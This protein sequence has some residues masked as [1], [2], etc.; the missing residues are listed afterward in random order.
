MHENV[1]L[2]EFGDH[3]ASIDE[4]NEVVFKQVREDVR[5][6]VLDNVLDDQGGCS[7]LVGI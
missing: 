6:L 3:D 7:D 5:V 1:T 4:F 2:E